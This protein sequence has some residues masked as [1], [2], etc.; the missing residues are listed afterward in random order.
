MALVESICIM[1]DLAKIRN[2]AVEHLGLSVQVSESLCKEA[3]IASAYAGLQGEVIAI[4]NGN[5]DCLVQLDEASL[6]QHKVIESQAFSEAYRD[7]SDEQWFCSG[8]LEVVQQ[9][10]S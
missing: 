3:G 9:P 2:P 6:V 4:A 7:D 8:V 5:G 1:L 10:Q